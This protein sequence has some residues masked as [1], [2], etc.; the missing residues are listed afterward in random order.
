MRRY[1]NAS[2]PSHWRPGQTP[3]RCS[4]RGGSQWVTG[5]RGGS[6]TLALVC[7]GISLLYCIS[8]YV[9]NLAGD[10]W[11]EQ[12]VGVASSDQRDD[13]LLALLALVSCFHP[14]A[15]F[16]LFHPRTRTFPLTHTA[17]LV[18][19]C[20]P[21]A[22]ARAAAG[23]GFIW[24]AARDGA[25]HFRRGK[26]LQGVS[27]YINM[28]GA[29]GCLYFSLKVI[30]VCSFNQLFSLELYVLISW[31]LRI[32]PSKW[33]G[34]LALILGPIYKAWRYTLRGRDMTS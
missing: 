6:D 9:G 32:F 20:C 13:S 8:I 29:N 18:R 3:C 7:R 15:W 5:L 16:Q 1:L 11:R 31:S 12:H 21:G 23:G 30:V 24:R 26:L 19:S 17:H 25:V 4:S 10:A 28:D 14:K 27:K 34:L 33:V 22:E 2:S